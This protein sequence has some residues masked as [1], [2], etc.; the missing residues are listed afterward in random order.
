MIESSE[1]EELILNALRNVNDELAA[2]RKINVRP[3]TVLFG[4]N[5][6][7]DSLSLVSL[8]VEVESAVNSRLGLD[9]SLADERAMSRPVLPFANVQ[10]LKDYILE[11]A[12]QS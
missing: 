11:I 6:E 2:D 1:V 3:D 9:V 8:V 10:T 7:L 12:R 5:A 4:M